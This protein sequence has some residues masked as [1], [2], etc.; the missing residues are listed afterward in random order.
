MLPS[1]INETIQCIDAIAVTGI[2]DVPIRKKILIADDSSAVRQMASQVLGEAG[3]EVLCA[4]DGMSALAL[5]GEHAADLLVCDV[6]M[7]RLDGLQACMLL[8]RH[9][10]YAHLPV[11]ML[12]ARQGMFDRARCA[13]AGADEFLGKPF[14]EAQL[15]QTVR[16]YMDGMVEV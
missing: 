9:P 7:P 4:V 8:R 10:R 15:L 1:D 5:L 13:M 3:Y 16:A 6:V 2:S 11:V 14:S 12:S